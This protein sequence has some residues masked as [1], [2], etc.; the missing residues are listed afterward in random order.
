MQSLTILP[1]LETLNSICLS[2]EAQPITL[3]ASTTGAE[4]KCF[5]YRGNSSRVYS[6]YSRT[7]AGLGSSV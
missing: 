4:A 1:Y 3:T 5:L 7:L 6:K 2:A